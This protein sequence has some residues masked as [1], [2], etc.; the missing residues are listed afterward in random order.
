MRVLNLVNAAEAPFFEDQVAALERRG[1]D[2]ETLSVPGT[3]GE[4]SPVDYCRFLARVGRHPTAD[5][6][7]VHANY[8]LT[9]P[10]AL[11]Q[12]DVPVVCSFWGTDLMGTLAPLSRAFA[13]FA[14]AVIVP[15]RV[16]AEALDGDPHVV[17]FGVDT[18]TFQPSSR[19]EARD[20]LGWRADAAHVLFPY[21]PARSVKDHPRAVRVVDSVRTRVEADVELQTVSGVP[22]DRMPTYMNAAD[23]LL[24]TSR[25]EAGPMVVREAMACNLPVVS[26]DVGFAREYLADVTPSHVCESDDA[27]V[28]G[29]VDVLRRGDRSDG[30]AV[31]RDLTPERTARRIES[32]YDEVVSRA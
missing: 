26:T 27:L 23:A 32:V 12:R 3:P 25:R 8:G 17:P 7:V 19:G 10:P 15:S 2:C 1:V 30:R 9:A 29:L 18:E 11:L 24:V 4:R 13:R 14:D 28:D 21:D 5:Y 16:M 22:H 6:D 20:A 31:V